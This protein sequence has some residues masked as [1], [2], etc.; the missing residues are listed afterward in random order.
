MQKEYIEANKGKMSTD[1]T[2][3]FKLCYKNLCCLLTSFTTW[4]LRRAIGSLLHSP[5]PVTMKPLRRAVFDL[6]CG[7]RP[8]IPT[9][10]RAKLLTINIIK[11]NYI[12]RSS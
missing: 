6:L 7:S 1:A 9:W 5:R 3:Y 12:S 11:Y 8:V 4:R 2:S 10:K